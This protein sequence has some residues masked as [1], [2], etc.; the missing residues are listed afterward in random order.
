MVVHWTRSCWLLRRVLAAS[1]SIRRRKSSPLSQRYRY[2]RVSNSYNSK[3][4]TPWRSGSLRLNISSRFSHKYRQRK[5]S[6]LS[7]AFAGMKSHDLLLRYFKAHQLPVKRIWSIVA[8][9]YV[10]KNHAQ[11]T[12]FSLY[13][14]MRGGGKNCMYMYYIFRRQF[15][16]RPSKIQAPS[17]RRPQPPGRKSFSW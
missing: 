16:R 3:V 7:I 2:G 12:H 14:I 1:R 4:K 5:I 10:D 9:V 11:E 13:V 6:F 17:S 15:Y 8:S